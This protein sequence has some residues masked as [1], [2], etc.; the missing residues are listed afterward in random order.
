[1]VRSSANPRGR[2]SGLG[3]S[4]TFAT[5]SASASGPEGATSA[6]RS[7]VRAAIIASAD[8]KRALGLGRSARST[9]AIKSGGTSPRSELRSGTSPLRTSAS[10]VSP[11]GAS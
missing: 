10:R 7:W 3:R 6:C 1:M 4:S 9:C 2:V 8:S 5:A 11:T